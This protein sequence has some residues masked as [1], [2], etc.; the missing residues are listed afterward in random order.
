MLRLLQE[1]DET[2]DLPRSAAGKPGQTAG[3]AGT[4]VT[5]EV[6]VAEAGGIAH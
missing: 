3:T 1:T 4:I 2:S 5:A 6:A